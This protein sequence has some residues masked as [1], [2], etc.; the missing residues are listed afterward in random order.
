MPGGTTCSENLR[1]VSPFPRCEVHLSVR[2]ECQSQVYILRICR[3]LGVLLVGAHR[4][5]PIIIRTFRHARRHAREALRMQ[6][7]TTWLKQ[8]RMVCI[9]SNPN[10]L[11]AEKVLPSLVAGLS[12]VSRRQMHA[13][14]TWL[15][16]PE[17]V[18]SNPTPCLE[19]RGS[20]VGRARIVS[21]RFLL[22][23]GSPWIAQL[24]EQRADN[25]QVLRSIRS[26]G[27]MFS[28]SR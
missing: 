14:T 4:I 8:A 27:T 16:T 7:R 15:M 10:P 3:D 18:G 23:E 21:L 20:S 28:Q 22:A 2:S 25:A 5:S 26:S 1:A 9:G 19:G 24:A 17:V 11:M 6:V 12:P 13:R